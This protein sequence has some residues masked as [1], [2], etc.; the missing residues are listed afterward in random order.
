MP[1]LQTVFVVTENLSAFSGIDNVACRAR[2]HTFGIADPLASP[3]GTVHRLRKDLRDKSGAAVI[4]GC[5]CAVGDRTFR[6]ELL[7]I[8]CSFLER[9]TAAYGKEK[10]P[11]AVGSGLFLKKLVEYFFY[12]VYL[13]SPVKM[14]PCRQPES[15][16]KAGGSGASKTARH[17]ITSEVEIKNL[18]ALAIYQENSSVP[19]LEI[20][21]FY[22]PYPFK[23][24]H[25]PFV[26]PG[27]LIWPGD[28]YSNII[29]CVHVYS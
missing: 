18:T 15:G 7:G 28:R 20:Q 8:C 16:V 27:R 19:H 5:K 24:G 13:F 1:N 17:K 10:P 29:E 22:N 6:D 26:T 23:V 14:G 9:N 12:I 4:I 11:A 25:P 3:I 21:I 2:F